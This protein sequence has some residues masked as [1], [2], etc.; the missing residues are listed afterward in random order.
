MTNI[1]QKNKYGKPDDYW[2]HYYSNGDIHS[3]GSFINGYRHGLW[4]YYNFN[5]ILFSKGNHINGI[6]D[7]YWELYYDNGTLSSKVYYI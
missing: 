5:G 7:G 3:K 1:N 4:E 2:E 6:R